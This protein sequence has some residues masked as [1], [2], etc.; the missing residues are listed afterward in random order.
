MRILINAVSAKSGG[1]VTYVT[2][3]A[4]Q[5]KQLH[6]TH[7]YVFYVPSPLAN[8]LSG[9]SDNIEIVEASVGYKSFWQRILWDQYSVRRILEIGRFDVLISS[10]DFGMLLPPCRQ[11]LL[12]RNALFFSPQYEKGIVKR[13]CWQTRLGRRLRRGLVLASVKFSDK[14]AVASHAM[15]HDIL[16]FVHL[17]FD[18]I[19]INSFGVPLER[20]SKG[21]MVRKNRDQGS[22]EPFRILYVSEYGDYK[23]FTVLF[24]AVKILATGVDTN[25]TLLTT[26][27]PWHSP[28]AQSVTREEDQRLALDPLVR[29]FIKCTG[30]V[31]YEDVP[32]LY[33]GCDLFVFP[34]IAESFGHPLVEAMA[35]GLPVLASDIPVCREICG[36]AAVY[37]D[38]FDAQDFA[39]KIIHL[40]C[41][42]SLRRELGTVG[43]RRA[44][45][46]FNWNDHVLRLMKSI[47]EVADHV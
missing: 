7:H 6:S 20:F 29:P 4:R 38:P 14:V 31:S 8:L 33:A 36:D 26:A 15:L 34:S 41:H 45:D 46:F 39:A 21:A 40:R 25:F 3:L 37:F 22:E 17:P 44:N 32:K 47:E 19:A 12:I 35:S 42:P 1:A 24:K 23:N 43:K 30:Y 16:R 11:L 10:S 13:Q 2:N 9:I 5:L 27:D 28:Q 18:R